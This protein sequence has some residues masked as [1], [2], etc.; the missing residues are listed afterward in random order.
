M[1]DGVLES[2]VQLPSITFT[3]L[4]LTGK[5]GRGPALV[6]FDLSFQATSLILES[7]RYCKILMSWRALSSGSKDTGSSLNHT[8]DDTGDLGRDCEYLVEL[9]RISRLVQRCSFFWRGCDL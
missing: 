2:N 8:S 4:R 1:L 7:Q 3:F 5:I 9:E 6:N